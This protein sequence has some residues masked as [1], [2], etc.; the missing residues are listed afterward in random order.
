[1]TTAPVTEP[2]V[3]LRPMRW[4]DL[5]AVQALEVT[6]FPADP[7][8]PEQFW[9]ELARVPHTR[10]YVVAED[11]G[12]L[13]GYAGLYAVAPQ[14]DV[15]TLAVAPRGRGR[16]VGAAL[17]DALIATALARG[18]TEMLLEVRADN[19]AAQRLYDRAGFVRIAVRRDYYGPGADAW[20]MRRRPLAAAS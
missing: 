14:A 1:M 10:W 3:S 7:W 9:G 4:W 2:A 16:G 11:P 8:S 5:A 13:L 17:L 6:V 20:V 18:C 12:G 15:Q 19:V